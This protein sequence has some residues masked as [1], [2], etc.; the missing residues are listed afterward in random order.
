MLLLHRGLHG[1]GQ[2]VGTMEGYLID[3]TIKACRIVIDG[4]PKG[5][6]FPKSQIVGWYNPE[7]HYIQS[8]RFTKWILQQ[9]K[10][11]KMVTLEKWT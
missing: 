9:K 4:H 6:W 11:I 7:P 10:L 8:F 2:G 1:R 3:I 5:I